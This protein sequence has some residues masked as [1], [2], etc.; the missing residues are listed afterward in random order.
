MQN[1][2]LSHNQN[3][4][5]RANT[6]VSDLK[7][8]KKIQHKMLNSAKKFVDIQALYINSLYEWL[9][10]PK[11]QIALDCTGEYNE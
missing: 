5:M 10:N 2:I 6:L 3:S 4:E 7:E 9:E 8:G 11:C 1:M